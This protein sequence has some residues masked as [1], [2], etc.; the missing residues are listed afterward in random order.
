MT[1]STQKSSFRKHLSAGPDF[2]PEG[3]FLRFVTI[4]FVFSTQL[5]LILRNT[6]ENDKVDGDRVIYNKCL[7]KKVWQ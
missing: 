2:E 1:E 3:P 4:L 5:I 7:L 6:R